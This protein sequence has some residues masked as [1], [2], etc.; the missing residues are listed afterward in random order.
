M[1]PGEIMN[2]QVLLVLRLLL[3]ASLYAFLG[4]ALWVLWRDLKRQAES[5]VSSQSPPIS[6][7]RDGQT[8]FTFNK[9]E[10]TIGRD[11]ACD[12]TLEDNTVST[13]H[14]RLSFH[15]NQW[16][17]EDL[18]STNGTF[19]NEERV[20]APIVITTGDDLR[21]GQVVLNIRVGNNHSTL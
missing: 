19:L 7:L 5:V 8:S 3:A 1:L 20:T 4:A 17:L 2:G 9:P 21:C 16:W 18:Q 6:L 10:V 14:A 12:A 13:E 11:L 15:H